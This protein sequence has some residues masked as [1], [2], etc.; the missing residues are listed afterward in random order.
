MPDRAPRQPKYRHYKPKDLAVVRIDG[1]DV[2][3]GKYDSPESWEK[4]GRVIAEWRTRGIG[5][6]APGRGGAGVPPLPEP[7][8]PSVS[9]VILAFWRFAEVHYRRADGTPT[10]E[11][12]AYRRTLRPLRQLYGSTPAA[13]FGPLRL[14][15]VRRAIIEAGICRKTTNQ[16]IRR[17]VRMFGWAV[18]NELVPGTVHHALK[19][20]KPLAR[21]RSGARE[22]G[23]VKPVPDA[24][25][26]AIRPHVSR[27][28]WAMIEL[29]RLTG[30]RPGE[31]TIMRT[32]DL[33]T[34]G[35]VWVFIPESHKTEHHGKERPIY[36]GPRAQAILRPWLRAELTAYL[37][38]PR[39]AMEEQWA[40]RR[41]ARK[42]PL[43]P[44]QRGRKRKKKPGRAPGESYSTRA[45]YHAVRRGCVGAGV[46]PWHPNQL[47]HNAA[48]WLRKEYG[49]DVA[50]VILGHSSPAV[51]EVYAEVDRAKALAVMEQVG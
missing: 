49:L 5:P 48:T 45:Y 36:I 16:R 13:E 34:S 3:L 44:S 25:V 18:E 24:L 9:E 39:E 26:D 21:G 35:K 15:A 1:R 41:A 47:R 12:D 32:I 14:K 2:Y 50:R 6:P 30:M 29:Q 31:V 10:G 38:S 37:F 46:E 20:V 7:A 17:I 28:V 42:T 51:T 33:D 8:A 40:A 27:Q 19:A 22:T 23:P 4:Y 11:I 43:T